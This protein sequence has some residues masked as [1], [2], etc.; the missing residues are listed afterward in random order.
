MDFLLDQGHQTIDGTLFGTHLPLDDTL[1][2]G[3]VPLDHILPNGHVPLD[4]E[5]S[6]IDVE[7]ILAKWTHTE[8]FDVAPNLPSLVK[9][10]THQGRAAAVQKFYA[11]RAKCKCCT[12]W[13]ETKP[14]QMPDEAQEKYDGVA[15]QVFHSEDHT[16]KT[17]G[18]LPTITPS[19]V[20]F[21]SPVVLEVL[22]PLFKKVE[23]YENCE[24]G[25]EE[26][27]HLKVL[28]EV[29][30]ELILETTSDVKDLH[31]RELITVEYLWTLYKNGT[32]VVATSVGQHRLYEVMK[33]DFGSST[34]HCRHICFDGTNYGYKE[35]K[36]CI[37]S[38]QGAKSIRE[39]LIYPIW[40]HESHV[41]L[42]RNILQRSDRVLG[43]QGTLHAEYD[44]ISSEANGEH[45]SAAH[46][47]ARSRIIIDPY[48]CR[49]FGW[50]SALVV[51][52][53]TSDDRS[54]DDEL[55][56]H[57]QSSVICRPSGDRIKMSKKFVASN[58]H[59]LLLLDPYIAGYSLDTREFTKFYVDDI[60]S[61]KWN[62]WA[63]KRIVF[64][65]DSKNLLLA[66]VKSHKDIKTIGQDIIPGK[67]NGFVVH[68]SGP[69]GTGK[70]LTAEALAD[71]ARRPF[72]RIQAETLRSGGEDLETTLE[73]AFR[74]ATEWDALLLI[75]EA[76][77]FLGTK[78]DKRRS[79]LVRTLMTS[80]EYYSGLLFLTTNFPENI[81]EAFASR[82]DLHFEYP[83]LDRQ[84]RCKLLNNVTDFI[85]SSDTFTQSVDLSDD[86]IWDLA[87][88]KLNGRELKNAAK[89]ASRLC[90][91]KNESLSSRHLRIAIQHT[92]PQ[93]YKQPE[94][95]DDGPSKK[96]ARIT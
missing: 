23:A 39:L 15:I 57:Y 80:L 64:A 50:S 31:A 96:R 3:H 13:V 84:A 62:D 83:S 43:Y 18:S 90:S 38:F 34:A 63:F 19:W 86:D 66:L 35:V 26:E 77:A 76:D 81:D 29:T 65:E 2:S 82:I 88:W 5:L 12:N 17:V 21:Q 47:K 60:H 70:T 46:T 59:W 74:L 11:G 87:R 14:Q 95:D 20:V 54:L 10:D 48:A 25:S 33:Y 36:F 53:L 69:P 92:S 27:R 1:P 56:E 30:D 7:E 75:D 85:K 16:K 8:G 49:Q 58:P 55:R 32:V 41:D 37:T 51:T 78:N 6:M 42:K 93:K 45:R 67:G 28:R 61:V 24:Q 71:E 91:I 44:N 52:R 68:L 9:D 72:L 4:G 94:E 73:D 22:K 79:S 89:V 40:F